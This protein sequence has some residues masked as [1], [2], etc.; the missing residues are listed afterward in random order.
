MKRTICLLVFWGSFFGLLATTAQLEFTGELRAVE[1]E[2]EEVAL[3]TV[4]VTAE[5][6]VLV[7]VTGAT[8]ILDDNDNPI[9]LSQLEVSTRLK[10]RGISTDPW[11]LAEEIEV[12]DE[13]YQFGLKGKIENIDAPNREIQVLGVI[14]QVPVSAKIR[15]DEGAPLTFADLEL[16]QFVEVEGDSYNPLVASV[17][18]VRSP[19]RHPERVKFEG[20]IVFIEEPELQVEIEGVG[21]VL[22]HIVPE[23]EIEGFLALS[24]F[25][26]VSGTFKGD[27]SV[28]AN[29]ITVK[30]VLELVPHRLEMSFNET[31]TV[32]AI[33]SGT[34]DADVSVDLITLNPAIVE[35]SV[36]TL[37]I[38][39]GEI[40]A[41]FQV[42]SASTEGETFIQAS[43][44][45]ET[46]TVEVQVE[47][48]Y[49][50]EGVYW[51]P[52]RIEA[53]PNESKEVHLH[54]N[55]PAPVDF[56]AA[57]SLKEGR[58]EVEFPPEVHFP[59]GSQEATVL[60][61]I[62]AV[63]DLTH[64]QNDTE[65]VVIQA[66]LPEDLGGAYAYLSVEIVRDHHEEV[67]VYWHPEKIKVEPNGSKEVHLHLNAPA[68]VDFSAALSLKEGRPEVEFP[69]EV[70]F[71][72]GSKHA[73][74]LIHVPAVTDLT[75]I[76]NDTEGVVIQA[77]LPEDLGGAYAYLKVEIS[78]G[79]DDG[80]DDDDSEDGEDSEGKDGND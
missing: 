51:H 27:L 28:Q 14:I 34:V 59:Q 26:Q 64:I 11:I 15:D 5:F 19:N 58:P 68:P 38:L 49:E 43:L 7:R 35:P 21:P 71:L 2:N 47:E 22:V 78:E 48:K 72:Q 25:V 41:S 20:T 32:Q 55:A 57:L 52:E 8:E 76:Q 73:T 67:E 39:A 24:V 46:A 60:I 66:T 40:S 56:S 31:H 53:A 54:L 1:K 45:G 12:T 17:V 74:V 23:T 65:G 77:T 30:G 37:V 75:Y 70:H 29:K 50:K 18:E 62:P 9:T 36:T 13:G 79:D 63:T 42:H 6:D 80:E 61:Y 44:A 10:I 69:P 4:A 3:L 33:L 16:D